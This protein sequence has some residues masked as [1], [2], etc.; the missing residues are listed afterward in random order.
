MPTI[1]T[2]SPR[3]N[4]KTSISERSP[5]TAQC[6]TPTKRHNHNKSPI[7]GVTPRQ[8]SDTLTETNSTNL[9][10]TTTT[11]TTASTTTAA[12]A[13]TPTKSNTSTIPM[14]P[15]E[16]PTPLAAPKTKDMAASKPKKTNTG[17]RWNKTEDEKLKAAVKGHGARNWKKISMIAFD[18]ART[19]VQCLHRWQKVLRPGLVKGPWSACEDK[20]V[21][22][23]VTQHG[24]GNIKWSVIA[25]KLPG[26]LGKQA[27]ERWYNHLDP[28]LN[29]E[30]WS[31]EEDKKLMELQ[32]TMGNRWCE[33]AK[34]LKGRSENAVKNRWNSAKRKNK[35][36][37]AAL[38]NGGVIK[39]KREKKPKK[40]RVKKVRVKKEKVI[41][42]KKPR[43]LT[44]K[45]IAAAE[46]ATLL[47]NARTHK[48]ISEMLGNVTNPVDGEVINL[49]K[50]M[51]WDLP[52][53][54][55]GV[56]GSLTNFS[57]DASDLN[58][59]RS[60]AANTPVSRGNGNGNNGS[61]QQQRYQIQMS[62]TQGSIS[63]S[64]KSSPNNMFSFSPTALNRKERNNATEGS[65][66]TTM[67]IGLS[68]YGKSISPVTTSSGRSQR[69]KIESKVS[70]RISPKRMISPNRK[71]ANSGLNSAFS[72]LMDSLRDVG[73]L[74][75]SV[76]SEY[77]SGNTPARHK[78]IEPEND[79]QE[80]TMMSPT[81]F[82]ISPTHIGSASRQSLG[83][84]FDEDILNDLQSS[85][86]PQ[87]SP[88][89]K[90]Q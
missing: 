14:A 9:K 75:L 46:K 69:L 24:V 76:E 58:A 83:G 17:G 34:M 8:R 20:I 61:S 90:I 65:N 19:D 86:F 64:L 36:M 35:A 89:P 38:A 81:Y 30:P 49:T 82:N 28:E 87:P 37:K 39:P 25:A 23:L 53:D 26:R 6:G 68:I 85:W 2:D 16:V 59:F 18:G 63:A 62:P 40:E 71:A 57:F 22:D 21:F 27:R 55:E 51:D 66:N 31:L 13:S 60:P 33:I 11:T 15:S 1:N 42:E 12:A 44:K 78:I 3:L 29:K 50:L 45:Q 77:Q 88:P 70:E 54:E 4:R 7:G 52:E 79:R 67:N 74:N 32:K 10:V 72:P 5:D 56:L 73:Q 80:G 84:D 47:E 48:S 43:K 41:K